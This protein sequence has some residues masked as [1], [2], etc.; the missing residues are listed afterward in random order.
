MTTTEFIDLIV[1]TIEDYKHDV[2][3]P[4]DYFIERICDIVHAYKK[5]QE[6]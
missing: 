1:D 6:F 2:I 3:K 4:N 5:G